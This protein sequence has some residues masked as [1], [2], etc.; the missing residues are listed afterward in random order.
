M[1]SATQ[2]CT[3][4]APVRIEGQSVSPALFPM[5]GVEPLVGRVFSIARRSVDQRLQVKLKQGDKV[6]LQP[7]NTSNYFAPGHRLRIE[8]SSSNFPRFDR[9]PN[10][11]APFGTDARL[12]KAEQ[13][14][15][16]DS[17]RPSRLVL[18]IVPR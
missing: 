10:T 6:T 2:S 18:P 5:L 13:T 11:G 1:P 4:V 15:F 8:V 17:G 16:H 9:N 12:A 3:N 7:L 14:V